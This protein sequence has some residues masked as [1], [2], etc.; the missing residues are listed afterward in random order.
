MESAGEGAW[1]VPEKEGGDE[2][3]D[4]LLDSIQEA[5]GGERDERWA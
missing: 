2:I 1:K 3:R 5:G 4:W